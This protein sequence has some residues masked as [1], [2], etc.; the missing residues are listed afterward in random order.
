MA[1]TTREY[2]TD[3]IAVIWDAA[4]CIH[5]ANCIRSLPRVF[6]PADRPWIHL[7]RAEADAVAAAVARCPTGALHARRLDG[8]PEE[9]VPSPATITVMSNGPLYLH[10]DVTVIDAGGAT[11]RRDMRMALCRCGHSAHKPFCDNTHRQI[12]FRAPARAPQP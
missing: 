6:N 11:I 4:R 9:S 12:G 2:R 5:S 1:E 10:G 8:G 7:E 3:A